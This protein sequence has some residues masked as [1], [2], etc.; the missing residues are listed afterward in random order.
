M[1]DLVAAFFAGNLR[2]IHVPS[3]PAASDS[4][5]SDLRFRGDSGPQRPTRGPRAA[6][7]SGTGYSLTGTRLE[8]RDWSVHLGLRTGNGLALFDL[9][10]AGERIAYE[11]SNQE[12]GVFYSGRTPISGTCQYFDSAWQG[13]GLLS[14]ELVP[15]VDCPSDATFLDTAF[16]VGSSS[17][18]TNRRAVCIFEWNSG[19][20]LGR[21]FT[22]DNAGGWVNYGGAPDHV[23]VIRQIATIY[24]YDYIYDVILHLDGSVEVKTSMTGYL[25]TGYASK[26]EPL[27]IVYPQVVGQLHQHMFAWKADLDIKGERNAFSTV[28]FPFEKVEHPGFPEAGKRSILTHRFDLKKTENEALTEIVFREPKYFLQHASGKDQRGFR[29]ILDNMAPPPLP[30]NELGEYGASFARYPIT[31]TK[32]KERSEDTLSNTYSQNNPFFPAASASLAD[33]YK[34]NESIVD[35][36]LVVWVS[37]GVIHLPHTEDVPV[38]TT[39]TSTVRFFLQPYNFFKENPMVRSPDIVWMQPKSSGGTRLWTY[40]GDLGDKDHLMLATFNGTQIYP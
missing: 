5:F 1:D 30:P 15:G 20:P 37:Q 8:F 9:R 27:P 28:S 10:F 24:N 23:V 35:E 34:D 33:F 31:V 14:F 16:L 39:P 36:D 29:F 6:T 11:L 7:G 13:L 26:V 12:A 25:Q 40:A 22:P 17:P 4:L 3:F 18:S 21:H 32:R 38:T 2:V 19:T